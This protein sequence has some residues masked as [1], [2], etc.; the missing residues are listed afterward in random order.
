MSYTMTFDASHKVGRSGSHA[1]SFF[2]HI[3]R[4]AD[5][6]AGFTFTH[7]NKNIVPSR[8]SSNFTRVNDGA[9][10]FRE[11]VSVD[12]EAPSQ[13]LENYLEERLAS[14]KK[15][16][17]KDAVVMRGLIL[18]LD[19][20]WFD[21]HNPSWREDGLNEEAAAHTVASLNWVSQEFGASN[22]VG[23]S[24][25]L[26]EYNPQLQVMF[27][28]V[29][30]DGRL[31]QKEF[32]KGPQDLRRQHAELRQHMAEAG[33]DVEHKVTERST[34]HLS[35]SE[36]QAKTDRIRY[37]L[38]DVET[39]KTTYESMT[40]GLGKRAAALDGRETSIVLQEQQVAA[41]REEARLASLAAEA[42]MTAAQTAQHA[43]RRAKEEAERERESLRTT[44]ARLE[45]IPPDVERWLDKARFG[46][47]PARDYFN[48]AAA[49][50]RATRAEVGRLIEGDGALGSPSR[51]TPQAGKWPGGGP[52][53][54]SA[55]PSL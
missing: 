24:L 30:K 25:H 40:I 53:A 55:G 54:P 44:N 42:S 11:L 16:L 1:R 2:R 7:S 45:S 27:T 48:E 33:Y 4:D 10:G 13:E 28:P 49:Q 29:T 14:V 15:P 51:R 39:K 41:A 20:K 43:A 50:A 31:A 22:I 47:K 5:L 18:Q 46:G 38:Q 26:D 36:F 52:T 32:F 35:S 23:F 21:D 37:A 19:P 8:T 17:R 6:A 3:A 9:G 34:E 12:G